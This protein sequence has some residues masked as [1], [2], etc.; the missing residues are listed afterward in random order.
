MTNVYNHTHTHHNWK[1]MVDYNM[2]ICYNNEKE[3]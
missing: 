3:D 2:T 1:N